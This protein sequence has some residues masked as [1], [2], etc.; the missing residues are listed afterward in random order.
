VLQS[1]FIV[2]EIKGRFC[3]KGQKPARNDPV[4][5]EEESPEPPLEDAGDAGALLPP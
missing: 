5:S 2:A 3:K 1:F 4:Q